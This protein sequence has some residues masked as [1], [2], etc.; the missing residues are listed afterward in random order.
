MDCMDWYL[1]SASSGEHPEEKT[2]PSTS[3]A[4]VCSKADEAG[5]FPA[6]MSEERGQAHKEILQ[7]KESVLERLKDYQEKMNVLQSNASH[8]RQRIKESFHELSNTL[9]K[10][11]DAQLAQ[12]ESKEKAAI[13]NL[14]NRVI[15]L[16]RLS[17]SI[18]ITL[19]NLDKV[20]PKKQ[21][22]PHAMKQIEDARKKFQII[23]QL[24]ETPGGC[25]PAVQLREWGGLRHIV[26]PVPDSLLFDRQSAN[27]DLIVSPDLRQVRF[28]TPPLFSV[29]GGKDCFTPGLFLLGTPG[30][31][32]GQ[33]YWEV[34]VGEKTNWIVGIVKES[35]QRKGLQDLSPKNGYWVLRKAR[36]HVFYC[37]ETAHLCPQMKTSP[38]R[39]GVSLDLSRGRLSFCDADSSFQIFNLYDF[40]AEETLFAFFCPGIP[41]T[42]QDYC[43]LTLCN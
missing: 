39:I 22:L 14:D 25:M 10:E 24:A 34:D 40:F 15:E 12:E 5:D 13:L 7:L 17:A 18:G 29:K 4:E 37:L 3:P 9:L 35:V 2:M 32:S 1:D 27:P 26:K 38:M 31:H 42:V 20:K 16:V 21:I 6:S 23:T 33:H 28:C 11:E 30:F 41:V 8:A 43:P 36:D 19:Q